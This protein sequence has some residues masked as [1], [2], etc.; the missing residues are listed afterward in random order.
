[1]RK[2]VFTL[3]M[4]LTTSYLFSQK[5]EIYNPDNKT[6]WWGDIDGLM[7]QQAKVTLDL[8][9]KALTANP[10]S[11]QENLTRKMALIMIDNVLHEEKAQHRPAVQQ[12]YRDRIENAIN[13]IGTVKVNS[14]AMVWKLYNHTFIV[15][16]PSV[17]IG[18]DIQRGIPGNENF[19]FSKEMINR[20]INVVD[21]LFI[22]LYHNDHADDWV[23]GRFIEQKK[24]VVTPPG[25][26]EKLP[27]YSSILH[28]ERTADKI[29]EISLPLKQVKLKTVVCP[30]HQGAN[31]L[32][33]V[34]L[35]FS[36]EGLCFTHTGD[37]S[38]DE[39]LSWIDNIGDKYRID[40]L[41]INSWSYY[42]EYRLAK[43]FHPK[44][45]IP[46]HE[47]ELNHT[48][49][50]REPY[51]LNYTRLGNDPSWPWIQ[52]APGEKYQYISGIK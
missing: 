35:V 18:F 14:G 26:W 41:M 1:M 32:N 50:H 52:M 48:I 12:F 42:P 3:L 30:G 6:D 29:Q 45:I 28:P 16:T 33:N 21:V 2:I 37:Q 25:L 43:G 17:T 46:G 8:V 15:K 36:P 4:V 7:D 51:W 5:E 49:D 20:L 39:D 47:N 22:T 23:A 10:P 24:P 11:L 27:I 31:I 9:N 34:Y 44:L 40:V 19:A 13:E 38:N